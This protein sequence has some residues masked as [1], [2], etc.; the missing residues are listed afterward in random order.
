MRHG[1]D[2]ARSSFLADYDASVYPRPSVAVDVVLLTARD[3]TSGPSFTARRGTRHRG[4]W[5][6]PGRI[7]AGST[8]RS[9][10]RRS[11]SWPSKAGLTTSSPSSSIP[12]A[13]PAVILE[14]GSSRWPITR[15]SSR[16]CSRGGVEAS[17]EAGLRLVRLVV[18]WRGEAG[19]SG[20]SAR[21]A[22]RAPDPGL[23]PCPDPG[24][25][26]KRIRGKLD[27]TPI[28]FELL[29]TASRC[30][31]CASS[32]RRS[33]ATPSTR[34]ASGVGSSTAGSS[35]RRASGR[36]TSAIGPRSCTGSRT[37]RPADVRKEASPWRASAGTRASP[38]SA[39]RRR[40]TSSAI[41]TD[42][43]SG[44]GAASRSGSGRSTPPSSRSR[45]TTRSS[46]SCSTAGAPTFRRSSPR[47]SSPI[48]WSILTPW[49]PGST[50]GSISRPVSTRRP[51]WTRSPPG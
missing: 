28:G 48:G 18:P 46:R 39:R 11:E 7:R 35:S 9:T 47:G 21:R 12:S 44:P 45:S 10:R 2:P 27:Y 40:T 20:L 34:T 26:V 36:P 25:A 37:G 19:G 8:S 33:S 22:G 13:H 24:V 38:T 3:E 6:L 4:R 51:R 15:S 49:P 50:S 29:P 16:P 31:T 30:A 1:S 5:A 17:H 23:R 41:A 42:G 14:R 43:R 32:T